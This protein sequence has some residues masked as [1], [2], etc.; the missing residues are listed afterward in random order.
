MTRHPPF[1]SCDEAIADPLIRRALYLNPPPPDTPPE[2]PR[3]IGLVE[4]PGAARPK[5][6]VRGR[7][8]VAGCEGHRLPRHRLRHAR[9][10]C[11]V[12]RNETTAAD[13]H[14][15]SLLDGRPGWTCEAGACREAVAGGGQAGRRHHPSPLPPP[16]RLPPRPVMRMACPLL[17]PLPPPPPRWLRWLGT[18]ILWLL[19]LRRMITAPRCRC[20]QRQAGSRVVHPCTLSRSG[21]W[22]GQRRR[23]AGEA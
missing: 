16:R 1:Q 23:G 19:L 9:V 13:D 8:G 10:C 22:R 4:T 6:V 14:L 5:D 20:G 7:C 21:L 18:R 11:C 3:Y 12:C 2:P 17:H 15:V